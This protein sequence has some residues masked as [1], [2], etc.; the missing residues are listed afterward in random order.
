MVLH[1]PFFSEADK[2]K[3]T[4]AGPPYSVSAVALFRN[5]NKPAAAVALRV[6]KTKHIKHGPAPSGDVIYEYGDADAAQK[7]WL[8]GRGSG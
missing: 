6:R 8:S 1:R 7:L 2:E 5:K 3:P 4:E